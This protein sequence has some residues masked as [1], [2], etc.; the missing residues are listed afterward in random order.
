MKVYCKIKTGMYSGKEGFYFSDKI[1]EVNGE[2]LIMFY[3]NEGSHPYRICISFDDI[4][5]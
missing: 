3:S 1:K 4:A 5:E 2:T